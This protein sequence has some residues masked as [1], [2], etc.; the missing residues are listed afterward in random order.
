VLALLGALGHDVAELWARITDM[1]AKTCVAC[2]PTLW[3]VTR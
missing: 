3:C 2:L 1:V